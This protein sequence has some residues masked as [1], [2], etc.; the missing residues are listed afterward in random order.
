MNGQMMCKVCG[1]SGLGI[2]SCAAPECPF[3]AQ[4]AIAPQG[5]SAPVVRRKGDSLDEI[6]APGFHLEQMDSGHWWLSIE[7]GGEEWH[8]NLHSKAKIEAHAELNRY[9]QSSSEKTTL[10]SAIGE[11]EPAAWMSERGTVCSV[12]AKGREG[13]HSYWTQFNIPLYASP[14]PASVA[15]KCVREGCQEFICKCLTPAGVVVPREPT[16]VMCQAGQEKARE[17]PKFPLHITSIYKA[18]LAA[19]P[20][21]PEQGPVA[22]DAEVISHRCEKCGFQ[23]YLHGLSWSAAP[24]SQRVESSARPEERRIT[25]AERAFAALVVQKGG[26]VTLTPLEIV[27]DYELERTDDFATENVIFTATIRGGSK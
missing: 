24:P 22:C 23:S 9:T 14:P 25:D 2:G 10:P 5:V 16:Q 18:M 3:M 11:Q 15:E 8:V 1:C 13:D 12:A 19:A 20:S 17:W 6:C 27:R 21:A 4:I 7:S 26:S